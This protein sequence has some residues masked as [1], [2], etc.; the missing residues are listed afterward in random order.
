VLLMEDERAILHLTQRALEKYG[1]NALP[2][3]SSKEALEIAK[4]HEDKIHLLFADVV[5]PGMNGP[6]LYENVKKYHPETKALYMSGYTADTLMNHGVSNKNPNF[7]QKPFSIK[8]LM[9][10]IREQIDL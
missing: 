2:A 6:T 5:M 10:K 8:V 9:E 3:S 1:Y 4:N 7:L